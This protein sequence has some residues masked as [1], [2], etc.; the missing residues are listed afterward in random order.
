VLYETHFAEP[1][2]TN[3]CE[4]NGLDGWI[5]NSSYDKAWIIEDP[6]APDGDGQC[7]YIDFAYHYWR[8]LDRQGNPL[9]RF[10]GYFNLLP[11]GSNDQYGIEFRMSYYDMVALRADKQQ[12]CCYLAMRNK[13]GDWI[14]LYDYSAKTGEWVYASYLLEIG[15]GQNFIRE[16][17]IGSVTTNMPCFES[18]FSYDV[19]WVD[20]KAYTPGYT[21]VAVKVDDLRVSAIPEPIFAGMLGVGVSALMLIRK[22]EARRRRGDA[23]ITTI[24]A[25]C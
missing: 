11:D 10:G 24:R 14:N 12:G 17:Q 25:N 2:Y 3:G 6:T 5:S 22:R 16:A 15:D 7:L 20:L 4:L 1:A 8:L 13:E 23:G 19:Y 18:Y 9:L 21:N